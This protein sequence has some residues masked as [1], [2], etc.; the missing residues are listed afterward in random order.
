MTLLLTL[1]KSLPSEENSVF[2]ISDVVKWTN[3]RTEAKMKINRKTS[4]DYKQFRMSF[5]FAFVGIFKASCK[6]SLLN[7]KKSLSNETTSI[8]RRL[9]WNQMTVFLHD[10]EFF[11][12]CTHWRIR[13]CVMPCGLIRMDGCSHFKPMKVFLVLRMIF[14]S[15]TIYNI[16]LF[17]FNLQPEGNLI[18]HL[19]LNDG[20]DDGWRYQLLINLSAWMRH[21]SDKIDFEN[22]DFISTFPL[23]DF[24]PSFPLTNHTKVF[25][26]KLKLKSTEIC[27]IISQISTSVSFAWR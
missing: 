25:S 13:F 10:I 20:T 3:L 17:H 4:V 7:E 16:P 1:W 24:L 19:N 18:P 5:F 11:T 9:K 23:N 26:N 2:F 27:L 14:V 15:L 22:R 12:I 21:T 6:F 8:C